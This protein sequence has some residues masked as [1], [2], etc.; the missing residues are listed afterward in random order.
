MEKSYVPFNQS[1]T[2]EK[3]YVPFNQSQHYRPLD[4]LMK[5]PPSYQ[6]AVKHE[7]SPPN[8]QFS[9][10]VPNA[11]KML[12]AVNAYKNMTWWDWNSSLSTTANATNCVKSVEGSLN[13][14]G[15][16]WRNDGLPGSYANYLESLIGTIGAP[17]SVTQLANVPPLQ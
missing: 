15:L 2:M 14:G 1:K 16:P 12:R 13:Q 11:A 8:E 3:S 4:K 6:W 17:W 10:W 7:K 9:I 5:P